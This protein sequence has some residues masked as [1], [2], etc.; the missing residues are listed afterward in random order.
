ME[1]TAG[2]TYSLVFSFLL[3]GTIITIKQ[4]K[5]PS[6]SSYLKQLQYKAWESHFMGK[7]SDLEKNVHTCRCAWICS[8]HKSLPH[9]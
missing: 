6:D 3:T 9:L 4:E 1:H 8:F 2:T 7:I 5:N